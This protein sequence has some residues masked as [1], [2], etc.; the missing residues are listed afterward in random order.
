M[1]DLIVGRRDA[2]LLTDFFVGSFFYEAQA[3]YGLVLGGQLVLA[4][5]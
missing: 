1:D 2:Q 3:K 5:Q 4:A